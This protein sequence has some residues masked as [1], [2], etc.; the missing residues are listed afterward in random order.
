MTWLYVGFMCVVPTGETRS[1]DDGVVSGRSRKDRFRS[2]PL[3]SQQGGQESCDTFMAAA[4]LRRVRS[5]RDT[6]GPLRVFVAG[7]NEA[8]LLEWG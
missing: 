7:R 5:P 8:G 3:P 2:V 6:R 1:S 4:R